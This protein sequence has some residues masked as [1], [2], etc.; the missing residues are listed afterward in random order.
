MAVFLSAA[1]VLAVA[2]PGTLPAAPPR[3][4]ILFFLADD[5]GYN[6]ASFVNSSRGIVQ[7]NLDRLSEEGV[8]LLSYYTAPM[9]SPARSALLTGRY[10][11]RLGTQAN[12]IAG[13]APWGVSL[14]E[15]L[16]PQVC[17]LL[18]WPIARC[19]CTILEYCRSHSM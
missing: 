18:P 9:C 1:L 3:P 4:N 14:D 16:L 2:A 12:T 6:E 19:N 7:P 10:I 15:T 5:L 17:A 11:T 8:V 13:N